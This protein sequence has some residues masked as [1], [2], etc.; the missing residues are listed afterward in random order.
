MTNPLR[1][2]TL[3]LYTIVSHN[4]SYKQ[5]LWA[6][7]THRTVFLCNFCV[8]RPLRGRYHEWFA[9]SKSFYFSWISLSLFNCRELKRSNHYCKKQKNLYQNNSGP[10]LH[11]FWK[12][13]LVYVYYCRLKL[14]IYWTKY[15]K[16][17]CVRDFSLKTMPLKF[18]MASTRESTRGSP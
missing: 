17:F 4:S 9:R 10:I 8:G 3:L 5:L 18:W 7:L 2:V 16:C 11:L 14:K 6:I 1:Y 12:Q 15:V 13:Q